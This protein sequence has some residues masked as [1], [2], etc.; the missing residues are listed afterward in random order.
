[1]YCVVILM[2]SY[3]WVLSCECSWA[4][5]LVDT[6]CSRWRAKVLLTT[7][8]SHKAGE[9]EALDFIDEERLVAA[10]PNKKKSAP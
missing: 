3:Y 4:V 8:P 1:M 6:T 9:G 2:T 5:M 7:R 10:R